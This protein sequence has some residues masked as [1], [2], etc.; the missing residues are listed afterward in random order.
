MD[1]DKLFN[2]YIIA[3]DD[4][5]DDGPDLMND[6]IASLES[7]NF[8]FIKYKEL[9]NDSLIQK[10]KSPSF[11]I[12][13]WE[14]ADFSSLGP[15]ARN[16]YINNNIEFLKKLKK[17]CFCP[18]FIFSNRDENDIKQ[19]LIDNGLYIDGEHNYI[20]IKKKSD[21]ISPENED[22]IFEE[23]NNWLKNTA[24]IYVI[25]EWENKINK[26]KNNQSWSLYE[27][28]PDWAK[29]IWQTSKNDGV[30]E[31][32]ALGDLMSKNLF[33]RMRPYSFDSS[34]MESDDPLN[35]EKE[36]IVKIMERG[37]FIPQSQL[38]INSLFTGDIFKKQ[39]KYYVNITPNCDCIPRNGKTIDEL[40]ILCLEGKHL[41][42]DKLKKNYNEK[43]G[44]INE[45]EGN[46]IIF[47][48]DGGRAIEFQFKKIHT[49][50]YEDLKANR[51]GRLLPPYIVKIQ[52]KYSAYLQR[53]GLSR[54]PKESILE[55]E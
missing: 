48:L 1:L 12:L 28:K 49:F 20:F 9:P 32:E 2:G 11:I 7:K 52:Q 29:V 35:I 34:I 5:I 43:Y 16:T 30:D 23:I 45:R 54:I 38:D 8:P 21:L 26:E 17:V 10:F 39:S 47:P 18:I 31:S 44:Y 40:K 33:A 46:C 3:I 13:D 14:L 36:D 37:R 27:A 42:N 22:L 6:I 4:N 41:S 55:E 15:A 51:K 25:K 53:Q 50:K 19:V 24:S